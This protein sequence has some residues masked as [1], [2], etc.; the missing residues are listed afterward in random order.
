MFTTSTR[1]AFSY[2]VLG[3][4]CALQKI[5]LCDCTD[6]FPLFVQ[7][8][9]DL[10]FFRA[11]SRPT[12]FET[13]IIFRKMCSSSEIENGLLGGKETIKGLWKPAWQCTPSSKGTIIELGGSELLERQDN[14]LNE[15][16]RWRG[17]QELCFSIHVAIACGRNMLRT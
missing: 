17:L 8:T 9:D 15:D 11:R 10:Y 3:I 7:E 2:P 16:Q 6:N 5:D 14:R 12:N 4:N 13:D 1:M